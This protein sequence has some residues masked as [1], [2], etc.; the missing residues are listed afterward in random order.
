MASL[1]VPKDG[2]PPLRGGAVA[3][4]P[5]ASVALRSP[6]GE[7]TLSL[8]KSAVQFLTLVKV[9][10]LANKKDSRYGE[11]YGAER[12]NRT[13]DTAIFSRLLYR[14]SYFGIP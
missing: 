8:W 9:P 1:M 10:N 2:W 12:R 13:A 7:D 6:K 11:S 3:S 4:L 5:C 14:L